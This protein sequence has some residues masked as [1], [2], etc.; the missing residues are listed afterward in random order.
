MGKKNKKSKKSKTSTSHVDDDDAFVNPVAQGRT[1]E[2]ESSDPATADDAV[3]ESSAAAQLLKSET[4]AAGGASILTEE[5]AS[6]GSSCCCCSWFGSGSGDI[7]S[8]GGTSDGSRSIIKFDPM[9]LMDA[10]SVDPQ[11]HDHAGI[12]VS[13]AR[14]SAEDLK[15]SKKSLA[16]SMDAAAGA[17]EDE[18]EECVSSQRAAQLEQELAT[19]HD[20]IKKRHKWEEGRA[21]T[22]ERR[23]EMGKLMAEAEKVE[24][25]LQKEKRRIAQEE[26][27]LL[28]AASADEA[29]S[30]GLHS[31]QGLGKKVAAGGRAAR[32]FGD[33]AA[34]APTKNVVTIEEHGPLG[35]EWHYQGG[36][37]VV[38]GIHD[39]GCAAKV[40]TVRIGMV[41]AQYRQP[42]LGVKAKVD[43][44]TM[45]AKASSRAG[46]EIDR[47]AV[48]EYLQVSLEVAGR[49]LQLVF[50][51]PGAYT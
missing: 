17:D 45:K 27:D 50:E 42:Q 3:G 7:G 41:L 16:R 32:A 14:P 1:F 26:R 46:G 28:V 38:A 31:L 40:G 49:P 21:V 13:I 33:V 35:V 29:L 23:E 18:V 34:S 10:Q 36:R 44:E 9:R 39:S 4:V 12:L 47:S 5:D 22:I 19:L 11:L 24:A 8:H 15:V 51:K 48:T 25:E 30:A 2:D 6:S 43:Y 20:E 37:P